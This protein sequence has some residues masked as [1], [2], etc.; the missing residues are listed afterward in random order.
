MFL[1]NVLMFA[2]TMAS[3]RLQAIQLTECEYSLQSLHSGR[4]CTELVGDYSTQEVKMHVYYGD[5]L[6]ETL[7]WC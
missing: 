1:A 4:Q 2:A 6:H 3:I 5:E 7:P